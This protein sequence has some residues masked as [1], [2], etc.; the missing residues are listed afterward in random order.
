MQQ[1]VHNHICET[2]LILLEGSMQVK[3]WVQVLDSDS[4][5]GLSHLAIFN[6]GL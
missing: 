2:C 5:Q 1:M 6:P 3:A 4:P